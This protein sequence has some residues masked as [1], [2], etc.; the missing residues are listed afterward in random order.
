MEGSE[1]V[2]GESQ[3]N[4]ATLAESPWL[5]FGLIVVVVWAILLLSDFFRSRF[6]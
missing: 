5:G 4:V 1:F 6:R 3:V 2:L